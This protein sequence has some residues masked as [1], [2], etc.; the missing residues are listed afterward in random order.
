M[1]FTESAFKAYD[2]RGVVGTEITE[3]LALAVG[4]GL[5]DML[6]NH[7]PVAVGHDMRPDSSRL[8]QRVREGII[9][10]GRE[11]WDI[12]LVT[13]DM[14]YFAVGHYGLA[15]G[16]MVTASHNPG[17]YNGIKLC[18][19]EAAPI[20]QT[21]GLDRIKSAIINDRFETSERHGTIIQRDITQD[22]V[23]HALA[24][25]R[26]AKWPAYKVGVDAGNG[27]A[28]SIM[29]Q[30]APKVPLVISP[31]YFELDG[32]FPHHP[33]NPHVP[34]NL[35]DL[36][37]L[38]RDQGLDF[39]LA[40]D[41]DGDRAVIVDEQGQPIDEAVTGAALADYFLTK[42]PGS[43]VLFDVR[44]SRIVA[45][46]V[47]AAG[48]KAIRTPVGGSNIKLKMRETR[49][50]LGIE[51]SGHYY[52]R[53]NYHSDSGLIAALLIVQILADSGLK[54]SQ[55]AAQ[56]HRYAD[57]GEINL[58]VVDKE[59]VLRD[60]ADRFADGQQD[61]LDGLSVHY[62]DWW[63]N[64]RPSNTEPY[65]RIN[66]EANTAEVLKAK[67]DEVRSSVKN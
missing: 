40:F 27:M 60:L 52:F 1:Q 3:E 31:L 33:A 4:R 2:I 19:A 48:G 44:T 21:T 18:R 30:L 37:Q 50:V 59:Q 57:S 29:P 51:S 13:T 14:I 11:V 65:L 46:I 6:E 49:A 7:G 55:W 63:F 22:W 17:E 41:G 16:A 53:D 23:K 56:Y 61:N 43:T 58:G 32:T 25:V 12:G 26:A 66:V 64:A 28:G 24:F 20:G 39:G 36:D 5:A 8:A 38:I 54:P 10:Q 42:E 47:E 45:D 62:P 34:A 67:L 15:G 9:E 35:K